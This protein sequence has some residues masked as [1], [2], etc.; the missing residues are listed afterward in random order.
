MDINKHIYGY[1]REH[2]SVVVPEL[3]CFTIVDK[4]SEMR[5]GVIT[6]PVKVVEFNSEKVDDDGILVAYIA[7]KENISADQVKSEIIVFYSQL[8]RKLL[9]K[10]VIEFDKLGKLWLTNTGDYNFESEFIEREDS[11]GLRQIN[12]SGE[13]M[14]E[15]VV[16]AR[17]TV[18]EPASA[19]NSL[20]D[21]GAKQ[22]R[23]N[24]DRRRPAVEKQ[25]PV[26]KPVAKPTP[27][28]KKKPVKPVKTQTTKK[29]N[30]GFPAWIV[31]VLVIAAGLGVG[32]YFA[33]PKLSTF[34]G[35]ITGSNG[36]D[37]IVMVD[38][39]Q[40]QDLD[41]TEGDTPNPEASQTLDNA[42]DKKNALNPEK[43]PTQPT[44]QSKPT[45]SNDPQPVK[46]AQA[47]SSTSNGKYVLIIGSFTNH[48]SAEKYGKVL[49]NAGI[50][51]EIINAGSER[52]RISVASFDDKTEAYRQ[53]DQI[54]SKPYC[55]N[56]WVT[57]R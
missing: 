51:Y 37:E 22:Y 18:S 21:T 9:G 57:R 42:T 38:D 17:D 31:V 40:T 11:Y 36:G 1:L 10:E 50:N 4:P 12:L 5:N 44:T 3:G 32:G 52:F 19:D 2:P 6:P 45:V 53:A 54:R 15:P 24:T 26:A 27:P 33:Y 34:I 30:S 49:Q 29:A 39:T 46:V 35:S 16:P 13:I 41:E 48:A 14:P 43:Q 20:F 8:Q 25:E 7:Q 23:E 55:E 47:Q 56:V 28:P